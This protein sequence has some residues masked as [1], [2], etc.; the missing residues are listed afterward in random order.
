[1]IILSTKKI[2]KVT[3]SSSYASIAKHAASH[4]ANET[5]QTHCLPNNDDNDDDDLSP[6]HA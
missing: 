2:M 5:C 4:D 3:M 1:M 6:T